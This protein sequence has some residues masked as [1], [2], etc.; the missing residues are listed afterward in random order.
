[1]ST[2]REK[3]G[4]VY[5][6]LAAGKAMDAFEKYYHEDV[7][8]TELGEEPRKGKAVNREYEIKFFSSIKQVNSM[9]VD[10]ITADE[11]N[12]ITMVESSMDAE[13]LDGNK[14]VMS[15]VAVQRWNGDHIVHET[16]YH[17]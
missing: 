15:Q 7:I 6:L 16:F 4:Q 14:M 2:Y 5:A 17:K 12:K 11:Y 13:F 10:A 9:S 1:M 8:M 3:I